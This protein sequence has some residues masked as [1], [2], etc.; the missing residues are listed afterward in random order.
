MAE[1]DVW[2]IMETLAKS[3]ERAIGRD[4]VLSAPASEDDE[5]MADVGE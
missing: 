5:A 4:W 3:E 1:L 2:P